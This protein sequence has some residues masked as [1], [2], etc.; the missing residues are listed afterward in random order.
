MIDVNG[1]SGG[2]AVTPF[3]NVEPPG[4]RLLNL[5]AGKTNTAADPDPDLQETKE[6]LEEAVSLE[7]GVSDMA[8]KMQMVYDSRGLGGAARGQGFLR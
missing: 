6:L 5:P 4:G 2:A 3:D 7:L 1:T 8:D